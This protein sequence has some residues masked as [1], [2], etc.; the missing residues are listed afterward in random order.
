MKL[1]KIFVMKTRPE[2][3][4][5]EIHA[6]M[7]FNKV[8][9]DHRISRKKSHLARFGLFGGAVILA[10]V[11]WYMLAP[12]DTQQPVVQ[13]TQPVIVD[14]VASEKIDQKATEEKPQK[15]EPAKTRKEEPRAA[16]ELAQVYTEA[17]PLN[18]YP[19][20]YAYFQK[21]LK[22]PVEAM[23]DSI[24][25]IVSVSFVINKQGKPEQ[26]KI[27]NSLGTAFDN[28]TV[29]VITGMPA[30]K[31]ASLNGIP[32]PARISMPLTF[33]VDRNQKQP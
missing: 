13:Q 24:E 20:L 22:Y 28:E 33:Q 6:M 17:E 32:V 31:A 25:G 11:A 8:L 5:H 29:R 12:G 26:V 27:L 21:E 30:W 14:S 18:G 23:K 1:K 19:D 15:E 9:D 7:D 4:D 2:I 16:T 10:I 3:S